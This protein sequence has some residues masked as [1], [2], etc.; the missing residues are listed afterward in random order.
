MRAYGR[1]GVHAALK[2]DIMVLFSVVRIGEKNYHPLDIKVSSSI[3]TFAINPH[4]RA[5]TGGAM[6]VV[7][8]QGTA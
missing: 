5:E 8:I 3:H 4:N 2:E 1:A 6:S 7:I